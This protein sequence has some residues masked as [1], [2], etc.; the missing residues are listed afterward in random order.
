M[1]QPNYMQW[2][3]ENEGRAYPVAETAGRVSDSGQPLPDDILVDLGILVAPGFTGIRLCSVTVSPTLI[4]VSIG[5]DQGAL[6]AGTWLARDTVQYGAYPL[7]SLAPNCSGWITLGSHRTD[8]P[9]QYRFA[10]AQQSALEGRTIRTI[11]P[12]GVTGFQRE[13]GDPS[14]QATGMVRLEVGGGLVAQI[15]PANSKNI[16]L[17]V[18]QAH[19]A[20]Y[21]LPCSS[22]ANQSC[23]VPVIRRINNV[24]PDANGNITLRFQ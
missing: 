6:L 23:G 8:Q 15:D 3:N 24:P 20:S 1:I 14:V 13:S 7:V 21:A 2:C 4:S 17:R 18:D 19:Q 12:P 9:V 11:Q 22:Q 10:T 5:C 16:I